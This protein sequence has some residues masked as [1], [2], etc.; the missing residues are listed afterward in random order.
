MPILSRRSRAGHLAL[1]ELALFVPPAPA[2]A[3]P[4]RAKLALFCTI[5]LE[6]PCPPSL[7]PA[8]IGFVWRNC[9]WWRVAASR[10]L[11]L[12]MVFRGPP[13][14][15]WLRFA[16]STLRR[17]RPRC[18][19]RLCPHAPVPPSLALLPE[20][21]RATRRCRKNIHHGDAETT[22]NNEVEVMSLNEPK[23]ISVT[24]VPRW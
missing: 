10:A 8:R 12:A 17:G 20:R 18:D 5:A 22:E 9:P 6:G 19:D 2:T 23:I 4:S 7:L 14:A 16:H 21:H 15:D 1:P 13:E 24:S 11:P 3:R